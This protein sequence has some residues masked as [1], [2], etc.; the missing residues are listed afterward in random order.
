VR[1][2]SAEEKKVGEK[3]SCFKMLGHLLR[4]LLLFCLFQHLGMLSSH[5]FLAWDVM[6]DV[7]NV[8]SARARLSPHS[9]C[10]LPSFSFLHLCFPFPTHLF[11]SSV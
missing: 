4:S 1:R 9:H 2:V 3:N 10:T 11:L 8:L 6:C 5:V 7:L